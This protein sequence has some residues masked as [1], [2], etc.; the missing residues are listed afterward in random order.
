MPK[1]KKSDPST[2][3]K[4]GLRDR[5]KDEVVASDKGGNPGQWSARKAQ[6]V[7]QEYKK[8]GGGFKKPR[9]T[10]QKSL[11][12][13]GDEKWTTSDGKKARRAGGTARYLPEIA[14]NEL[15][16]EE[17]ART[18]EKKRKG[19]QAGKQFVGNTGAA[20]KARKKAVKKK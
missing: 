1:S 9:N 10:A 12:K 8:E 20:A 6:L 4:P 2:Y 17:K 18:N 11:Q 15:S 3:T 5:I 7:T 13:W 19:S 16:A 14:W